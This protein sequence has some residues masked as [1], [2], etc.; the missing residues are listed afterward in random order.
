MKPMQDLISRI[1]VLGV[2]VA[3][4]AS[5]SVGAP[6]VTPQFGGRFLIKPSITPGSVSI[7]SQIAFGPDGRL[8]VARAEAEILSF[9]YN[10]S[11]HTLSDQRGTGV[12]GMGVAFATHTVPGSATPQS[13][14]Y[15]SHRANGFDG[16]I[17][18]Y[19]DL[20]H[21]FSWGETA[22]GEVNVDIV[23]GVP[24]GDHSAN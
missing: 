4:T 18:R 24:L 14:M 2:A 9:A 15:V 16:T 10:S 23:K 19:S 5:D 11:T 21:N 12:S 13:Y 22:S 8:Y 6:T 3:C 1:F 7:P 17:S 20:N